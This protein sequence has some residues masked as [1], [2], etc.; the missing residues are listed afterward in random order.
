MFKH[1]LQWVRTCQNRI[2]ND[3]DNIILFAGP[4]GNGKS[5]FAFQI[6]KALDPTFDTSR[7]H[8]EIRDTLDCARRL[9]PHKG[10]VVL[11][12][13]LL[14]HRRHSARG[15]TKEM[16]DFLQVCRGL[17]LNI[18]LCFPHAGMLDRDVLDKRVSWRV[19]IEQKGIANL[20]ERHYETL[21]DYDGSEHYAVQWLPRNERPWKFQRNSGPLWED[22]LALK[23]TAAR[24][25]DAAARGLTLDEEVA[26][27]PRGNGRTI[28]KRPRMKKTG[29]PYGKGGRHPAMCGIKFPCPTGIHVVKSPSFQM[30]RD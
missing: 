13:E 14:M 28:D 24:K 1:P 4:P 23:V 2:R 27:E 21:Y 7:I 17:N 26:T 10:R 20:S 9:E 29:P 25:R 30:P 15:E 11:A 3:L 5:T 12:D 18:L 16:L 22:Y 8:F 6:A 19:D